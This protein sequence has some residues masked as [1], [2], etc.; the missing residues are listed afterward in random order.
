MNIY[1]IKEI[2]KATNNF[3]KP[4][5]KILIINNIKNKKIKKEVETVFIQKKKIIKQ[6]YK[7]HFY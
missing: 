5:A 4:E 1:S 2:V 3:L 6:K 7:H